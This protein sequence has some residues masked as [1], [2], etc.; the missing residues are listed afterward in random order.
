V[1]TTVISWA[2]VVILL[3]TST[4]LLVSR[5]WR[6]ELGFLAGQYLAVFWLVSQHWP[7][8][9]AAAKLVTGWMTT[10][11]LGMT[12]IGLSNYAEPVEKYWPQGRAFRFFLV[13]TVVVLTAAVVPAMESAMPGLG[14]PVI[15]GG[16]LLTGMGLIHLGTTS[17]LL[18]V[19]LGLLTVLAGF[20]TLYSAV[21]A[22][23]LVAGLL[24]VISLGLGLIGAY[25]LN[26]NYPEEAEPTE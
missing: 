4:G 21:E 26:S 2:C 15:A 22:S 20:E 25:L 17:H 8:G 7:I 19:I 18:R 10:S 24:A 11:A 12:L 5:D 3:A 6:R 23:I 14:M 1:V 16:I 13:G 9:M